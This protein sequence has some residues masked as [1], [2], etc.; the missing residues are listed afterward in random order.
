[1]LIHLTN[2]QGIMPGL[3]AGRVVISEVSVPANKPIKPLEQTKAVRK[4][5]K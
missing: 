1:M 4:D 3:G 2:I 5:Q